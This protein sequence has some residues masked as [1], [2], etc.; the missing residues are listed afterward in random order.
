MVVPPADRPK[1]GG[2]GSRLANIGPIFEGR[3]SG[4]TAIEE[5]D[6]PTT[7]RKEE[8]HIGLCFRSVVGVAGISEANPR[9]Y[10]Q[11]WGTLIDRISTTTRAGQDNAARDYCTTYESPDVLGSNISGMPTNFNPGQ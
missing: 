7:N 11:A 8:G 10:L 3:K 2:L 6:R 1:G 9:G 4:H 5:A